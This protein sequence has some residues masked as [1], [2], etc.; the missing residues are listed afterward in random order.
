[1]LVDNL[2]DFNNVSEGSH[3]KFTLVCDSGKNEKCL[4]VFE[5]SKRAILKQRGRIGEKDYCKFCQKTEE[6]SGRKNPNAKYVLDDGFLEVID[7]PLKA[8]LLGWIA[9]DGNIA[10]TGAI[11]IS[12]RD[13]D[14][15]TLKRLR[16][17]VC[18]DLPISEKENMV[19]LSISST[20]MAKDCCRHL[21]LVEAGA[22]AFTIKYPKSISEDLQ[23]YFIRGYFEGDGS[24]SLHN[25]IPRV[26]IVSN[27]IDMLN[28]IHTFAGVGGVYADQWQVNSGSEALE[29]LSKI[30]QDTEVPVLTRKYEKYLE[31]SSWVPSRSGS[32][33]SIKFNTTSGLIKFNKCRK[34]AVLPTITD[35]HA[36][37]IDLHVLEP[38]KNMGENVFLYSTG[39]KVVP[40]EGYYF[41]LVGRSSISKSGFSLANGIGIIDENY[42]GEILVPLRKHSEENTVFPCRLVQLVLL[43]KIIC[44]YVEVSTLEDTSRG[45]SGFGSTG[46]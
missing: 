32:G 6:F 5:R 46:K 4:E 36:S 40:P 23:V 31:L 25:R 11:T 34:E 43:P 33:S 28:G 3:K 2:H 29:F 30:Y 26:S 15:S 13:Y 9:S 20:R 39:I 38:I 44:E 12:V 10:K 41:M 24:I 21:G 7:T 1:M 14:V 27:S 45:D 17:I 37:G 19:S 35:I 22:K 8:Y 42:I 16:K 18:P